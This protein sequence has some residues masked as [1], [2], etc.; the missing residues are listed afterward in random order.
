LSS[1]RAEIWL[2]SNRR[3]LVVAAVAPA[4]LVALGLLVA[5][6][7]VVAAPVAARVVAIALAVVGGILL[8]VLAWYARQ[9]RLAYDGR[10]L[11]VYL[12]SNEPVGVPIEVVE[13]F[14]LGSGLRELPGRRGREVQI[15]QLAIRL[16]ER[17]T[18]WADVA[19]K[20]ALG[21][22][23]GGYVTIYGTWCEPLNL[24]VVNRLNAKLA[25]AHEAQGRSLVACEDE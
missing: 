22:W 20:P 25:G 9:P 23:C 5:L 3:I 13:C 4:L 12:R 16:A 14:F 7:V 15:A 8:V 11:L 10:H 17:A 6:D 18:D 19:V 24:E 1:Q 21:K 2:R